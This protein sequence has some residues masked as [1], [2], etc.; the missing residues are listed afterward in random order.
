MAIYEYRCPNC[1]QQIEKRVQKMD[2]PPTC[3]C[4]SKTIQVWS[5]PAPAVWNCSKGSL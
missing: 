1:G 4:G 3:E 5:K 2:E